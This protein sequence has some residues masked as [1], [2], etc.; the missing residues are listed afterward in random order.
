MN[1]EIL[2][3]KEYI[4]VRSKNKIVQAIRLIRCYAL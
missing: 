1:E 2:L 3:D 4:L